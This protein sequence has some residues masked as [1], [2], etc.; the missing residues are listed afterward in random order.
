MEARYGKAYSPREVGPWK[1]QVRR[2]RESRKAQ[3]TPRRGSG[4]S[5]RSSLSFAR[6]SATADLTLPR[7]NLSR[8]VGLP[9]SSF[10]WS[11]IRVVSPSS[12][13]VN[14]L[15]KLG[16]DLGRVFTATVLF[17][18]NSM[19]RKTCSSVLRT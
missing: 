17:G 2:G 1:S 12:Y 16:D 5:S 4:N 8:R 10:H 19:T 18:S 14:L 9:E 6:F 11:L 15:S 13:R 7:A 3:G